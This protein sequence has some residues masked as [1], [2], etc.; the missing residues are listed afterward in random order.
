MDPL[1][2]NGVIAV[3]IAPG[4]V[5][6]RL[7]SSTDQNRICVVGANCTSNDVCT[8]LNPRST[9]KCHPR[10]Y[11]DTAATEDNRNFYDGNTL[12]S[13]TNGF[14]Q[15]KVYDASG[16]LIVNDHLLPITYQ[17]LMP[18][19]ENRV[20]SEVLA[21]L[22]DYSALAGNNGRYPWAATLPGSAGGDF[23]DVNGERFGRLP[24]NPL[25]DT[26]ASIGG[27]NSATWPIGDCKL[28]S[29]GPT[30]WW[31]NWK[32]HMFYAVAEAYQPA[33]GSPSPCGPS[34][35]SCLTVSPPSPT[36]DLRAI[37]MVAGKKLAAV[38]PDIPADQV[39]DNAAQ[40]GIVTNYLEGENANDPPGTCDNSF[41]S[42]LATATFNDVTCNNG[43]C[44]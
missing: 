21:C 2:R 18:L 44:L 8:T 10:N 23:S 26:E 27:P 6:R 29:S 4:A 12:S 17:D 25:N 24:D 20:V 31:L 43:N 1:T 14:I 41:T 19:L 38:I 13:R 7:V 42:G 5:L 39:R 16:N 36:S 3:V 35:N 28:P 15:G 32:E 22:R 40:K 9:P 11:L 37:V 30:N 33:T 34:P